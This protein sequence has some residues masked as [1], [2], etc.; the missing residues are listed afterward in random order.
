MADFKI[1]TL[2]QGVAG[3]TN[4]E[5]LATPVDPPRWFFQPYVE[6]VRL[7]SGLARGL[8]LPIA[9]WRWGIIS[10]AQRDALRA[11]CTGASAEVYIA[12]RKTDSSNAYANYK[13]VMVWPSEGEEVDAT[14]RLDFVLR[15]EHLEVQ[16]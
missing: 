8:G 2:A 5:S 3:L 7:G 6:L 11:Y 13:A 14:R 15:F 16:S 10:G 4:L 9:E 12:T 1:A